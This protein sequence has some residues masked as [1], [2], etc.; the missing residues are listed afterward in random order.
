M[1][2]EQVTA[3]LIEMAIA[4]AKALARDEDYTFEDITGICLEHN[5]LRCAGLVAGLTRML[6]VLE[7]AL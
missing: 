1:I 7:R 4:E 3:D 6:D 2:V 5:E